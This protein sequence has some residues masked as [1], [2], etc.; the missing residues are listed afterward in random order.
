MKFILTAILLILLYSENIFCEDSKSTPKEKKSIIITR[1][2]II[3]K[4]KAISIFIR[5]DNP[6]LSKSQKD[7]L[8]LIPEFQEL[9]NQNDRFLGFDLFNLVLR[10]VT[11][12]VHYHITPYK[13]KIVDT[14]DKVSKIS[15]IAKKSM[16]DKTGETTNILDDYTLLLQETE[17]LIGLTKDL[18][19]K[20]KS[21]MFSCTTYWER[22]TSTMSNLF[23]KFRQFFE[24]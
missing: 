4:L 2:E 10:G 24:I 17:N 14:I 6:T 23:Q 1:K 8:E 20:P 3:P 19:D 7:F 5:K 22:C 12:L 11:H 18:E 13:G 9:L 15:L 16:Q 21:Y